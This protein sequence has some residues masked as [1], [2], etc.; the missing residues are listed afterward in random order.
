VLVN[1]FSA[2]L[3]V[4]H[5]ELLASHISR[6]MH[7]V[8]VDNSDSDEEFLELSSVL[9]KGVCLL[10][11][12]RNIGFSGGSNVGLEHVFEQGANHSFVANPDTETAPN[13]LETLIETIEAHADTGA[14]GPRV[15]REDGELTS[16]GYTFQLTPPSRYA[17][18]NPSFSATKVDYVEGCFFIVSKEA[19]DSVG[20]LPVE[21]FLYFEEVDFFLRLADKGYRVIAE[22]KVSVV[23]HNNVKKISSPTYLYYMSRNASILARSRNLSKGEVSSF[24]QWWDTE[25]IAPTRSRLNSLYPPKTSQHLQTFLDLGLKHGQEGTLGKTELAVNFET[26]NPRQVSPDSVEITRLYSLFPEPEEDPRW[27]IELLR[28]KIRS[29]EQLVEAREDGTRVI[30]RIAFTRMSKI[31]RWAAETSIGRRLVRV[32]FIR[33]LFGPLSERLGSL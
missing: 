15:V 11:T 21:Y 12:D 28:R 33:R 10:K 32:R 30:P 5:L 20:G 13:L 19:W 1:Y 23:H 4:R 24:E 18:Q 22:P 27:E 3:V 29:L 6:E 9:P 31:I 17:R 8:V 2:D 16:C 7:V 25:F 26:R 14:V